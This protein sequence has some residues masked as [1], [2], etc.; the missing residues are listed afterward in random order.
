MPG[1]THLQRAQPVTLGHH[2]LA[3]AEMLERDLVRL[4][5]A[6]EQAAPSPLGAGALAGSTLP[7]P[8]SRA[9]ATRSTPSPIATSSSTTCTRARCCASHLSRIG[10]EILPLGERRVGLRDA[11]GA[12]GDRLLDDA[13]K[14][15]PDVAEL[16]RA[17]AGTALG[18]L[19]GLLAAT[20]GLPLAY[21]RDLQEDKP[22][23]FEARR[24]V[25][26]TLAALTVLVAGLEFRR[27][28]MAEACA[29]RKCS[30]RTPSRSSSRGACRSEKPTSRWPARSPPAR[31]LP[32][33]APR[34]RPA[35]GP[36]AWRRRLPRH[37]RVSVP[38]PLS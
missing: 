25:R 30:R 9:C 22:G 26:N 38:R 35:P 16:A 15:N 11:A 18:R 28:R 33:A 19:V 4:S 7:L 12:G 1:Y 3:W 5:F 29:D 17:K 13:Q 6:A 31:S 36:A 37:N 34:P 32:P 21:N 23:V 8:P 20:Q 2:L 24:D 14:L 10:E 27:D